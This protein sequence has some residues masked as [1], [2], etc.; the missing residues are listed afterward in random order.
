M[1]NEMYNVYVIRV[2]DW[3]AMQ[4]LG[5]S[6]NRVRARIRENT[7]SKSVNPLDYF[8]ASYEVGSDRDLECAND[9]K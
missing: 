7:Y 6:V 1:N 8:I 4:R 9:L 3:K 2:D 5:D